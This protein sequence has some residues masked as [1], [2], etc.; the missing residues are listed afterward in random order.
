MLNIHHI[1]VY[2]RH[3]AEALGDDFLSERPDLFKIDPGRIEL[4]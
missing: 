3:T 1:L 2:G 4:K